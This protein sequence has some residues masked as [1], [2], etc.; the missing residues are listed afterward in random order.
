MSVIRFVGGRG[1]GYKTMAECTREMQG[2]GVTSSLGARHG[3]V[4]IHVQVCDSGE[5]EVHGGSSGRY[6]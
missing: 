3:G 2:V 6:R 5:L 1:R 4:G